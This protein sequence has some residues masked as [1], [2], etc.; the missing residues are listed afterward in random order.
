[1]FQTL[2]SPKLMGQFWEGENIIYFKFLYYLPYYLLYRLKMIYNFFFSGSKFKCFYAQHLSFSISKFSTFQN[3]LFLL[4]ASQSHSNDTFQ[5]ISRRF[6]G[7]I[8]YIFLLNT[9]LM[10]SGKS[11]LCLRSYFGCVVFYALPNKRRC[12][13]YERGFWMFFFVIHIRIVISTSGI[14]F[15]SVCSEDI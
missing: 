3:I 5:H 12:A 1:M 10:S 14:S 9:P 13:H 15:F 4:S 6:Q 2:G 7:L 11:F 8:T